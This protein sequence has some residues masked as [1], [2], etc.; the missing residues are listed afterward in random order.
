MTTR[1]RAELQFLPAALEVLETPASPAGRAVAGTICLFLVA[2]LAWSAIGEVDIVA[3]AQGT[4]IPAGKSKVVQPLEAGVVKSILVQDGDHVTAGQVL[5]A[6]DVT[7]AAAE[8]ARIA[9]ALLQAELD[10]AGLRALHDDL[11]TG[12]GLGGFR[13]PEGAT[14]EEAETSLAAAEARRDEQVAKLAALDQQIAQ[15]RAELEENA[16]NIAK[17]QASLPWLEQ[18]AELRRKLL[19]M[20]FGNRLAFLDAEQALTEARQETM[21]LQRRTPEMEAAIGALVRQREQTRAAYAHAVLKD[22]AEA[23]EKAAGLAQQLV[24]AAHKAEQTV[25]SAPISG[26]VQQLAVH[27]V[28]GVVTPAQVLLTVVPDDAPVLIEAVVENRDIGFV[29]AGQDVAVKVQTFDFTRYGLLHGHVVDVSRDQVAPEQRAAHEGSGAVRGREADG[30]RP[31]GPDYLAHVAL[32]RMRM[33]VDGHEQVIAPGMGVIAEIKSGRRSI[34]SYL[35]SPL[36]RYAHDG[37]RER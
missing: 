30:A 18:K 21:V 23:E 14:A 6:L 29:H 15:K 4:V 11:A 31:D 26:T 34:I 10:A 33:M 22:L 1:S 17:L 2:A 37:M 28:G 20:E 27:T 7:I 9:H 12:A 5:F 3:T 32:D 19:N 16:A 13:A 8:R 35:L 25:L 24:Q 36:Q